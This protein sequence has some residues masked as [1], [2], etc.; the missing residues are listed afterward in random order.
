MF[1]HKSVLM[2]E[3]INNSFLPNGAVVVDGTLGLGGHAEAYLKEKNNISSY[4][5]FDLDEKALK[6]AKE[7]LISYPCV[8]FVETN[9]KDAAKYLENHGINNVDT[10]LL[11]LGVSSMQLDD[12]GRGFSFRFDAPLNMRLDG[13]EIDTAKEYINTVSEEELIDVLTELGEEKYAKRIASKIIA[14]REERPIETTFDLKDIVYSAYPVHSRFG[15]VHPATKTFQA[16]RIAINGELTS[17]IKALED[18]PKLLSPGGRMLVI[19]FHS[20]EDR[21]VKQKFKSLSENPEYNLVTK[22][23]IVPS[24]NELEDNPRARSSKLRIIEKK[25]DE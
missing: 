9:Y 23:P 3:V 13:S 18:L 4:Y 17:L 24:S 7:K 8:H 1:T 21:I 22:K 25:H 12:G 5:G 2:H 20:L 10:I 14:R 15:K 6:I 16:I 11:D 19:T